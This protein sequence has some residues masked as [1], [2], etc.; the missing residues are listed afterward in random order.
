MTASPTLVAL[1]R[2]GRRSSAVFG[3]LRSGQISIAV[4]VALLAAAA[5]TLPLS[6]GPHS[7]PALWRVPH[8]GPALP[9]GDTLPVFCLPP[10]GPAVHCGLA[11][12][13]GDG[14]VG[15][16]AY[17]TLTDPQATMPVLASADMSLL[18]A[19]ADPAARAR[20][21]VAAEDLARE[22]ADSLHDATGS[23]AWQ[24]EYR[25]RLRTVIERDAQR[26]WEADDT[27]R[28]FRAL[29]R[30]GE[31]V[32]QDSIANDVGPAVAPYVGEA[33][34]R[35][36]KSTGAQVFS[37]IAGNP[38][39]LTSVGTSF[40]AALQDPQVQ[41]AFGRL[42]PHV[43]ELPQ[44]EVLFETFS[45]NMADALQ[46]D[47]EAVDVLG[48]A[49]MDPRLGE[50]LAA[51]RGNV[52]NFVHDLGR[53]LWGLGSG[54]SMNSLAGLSMKTVILGQSQSVVLLLDPDQAAALVHMM[55]GRVTLLTP[56]TAP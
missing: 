23:A 43:L 45:A 51:L 14:G 4:V 38:L 46:Q 10:I 33:F 52:A 1:R 42:G 11:G 22:M 44:T 48:R 13:R 49:A 41:A 25:S 50:G 53:A 24:S 19:L 39:D 2:L 54:N 37:L 15:F 7:G 18:W 21:R 26:A 31:P 3:W 47:P 30:A 9:A 16:Q 40:I 55:P 29:L 17:S 32:L 12:I 56:E 20:L 35:M 27:R 28:A 34:W 8:G 6:P 36:V 5:Y